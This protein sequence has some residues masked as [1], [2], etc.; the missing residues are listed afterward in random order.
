MT[1]RAKRLP[2][3]DMVLLGTIMTLCVFGLLMVFSA[4]MSET[5]GT[6]YYF[7]YQLRNFAVGLVAMVIMANVDYHLLRRVAL[8]IFLVTIVTLVAVHF[9]G[10]TSGGSQRWLLS[11]SLQPSEFAKLSVVLFAAMWLP[12]KGDDVRDLSYGMI[13]FAVVMGFV[14]GIVLIQPDMGTA[15][16]ILV[17]AGALFVVA[18]ADL[19]QSLGAAGLAGL[20]M[21]ITAQ[22]YQRERFGFFWDP[23]SD[24]NEQLAQVCQGIMAMGSGG[25]SGLGIGSSRFRWDLH[26]AYSDSILAIIGEELGLL[27]GVFLLVLFAVLIGRGFVIA[28]RTPDSFGRLTVI[29]IMLWIGFQA[30]FNLGGVV[31]LIP[32]TGVPLPFISFGGSSLVSLMMACG[33]VL[34]ISRQNAL[35]PAP[36]RGAE[37]RVSHAPDDHRRGN[38]GARVPGAVGR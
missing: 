12:M 14:V 22:T 21:V 26:A 4:S 27:G 36:E 13:P 1:A 10:G 28:L 35:A 20:A 29:G 11:K 8:P 9:V 6:T 34:N 32:F 16:T 31:A 24:K 25:L 30:M 3:P 18:G 37:Q 7:T 38:R 2:P 23:C 15:L 33:I 17:T 5:E 19:V